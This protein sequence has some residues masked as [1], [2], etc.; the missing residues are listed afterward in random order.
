MRD[1]W[2]KFVPHFRPTLLFLI[3][4]TGLMLGCST[5][6]PEFR[7]NE[8]E[9]HKQE[10]KLL[11]DGEEFPDYVRSDIA[12]LVTALFGTPQDP[13][14][15]VF[16]GDDDPAHQFVNIDNL[17][18]AAG[19]V[20]SDREGR[21]IG[22][23][24]EHCAQCHGV[25]GDG[26]GPTSGFMNPYPRDFRHGRFKFKSTKGRSPPTDEDL[27]R[28]IRQ[29]ITGTAMPSFKLLEDSEIDALVDYVK[30]LSLRG[31]FERLLI[32]E[33]DKLDDAR[34]LNLEDDEEQEPLI[35]Q[36]DFLLE[37]YYFTLLDQ[38]LNANDAGPSRVPPTPSGF[39]NATE[40]IAS[41]KSLF[42]GRA[43]CGQCHGSTGLG[44]G[45]TNNYDVWTTDWLE[46]AGVDP[47]DPETYSE[48][49]DAGA[50][51]P[52]TVKPR[53]LRLRVF[54]GGNRPE[55]IYRRIAHGIDGTPMPAASA[56]QEE[57]IWALVAY[58]M[59]MPDEPLSDRGIEP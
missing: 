7:F 16:E 38:W 53:N 39:P 28:V 27:R 56:L 8:V 13:S 22:L 51:P 2:L 42:H 41:G 4:L 26:K 29:G 15:P 43:N 3:A 49:I 6:Q 44:D 55:D 17:K 32:S 31:Q 52:R 37:D 14:F 36:L 11:E 45:Q 48:F 20:S 59:N 57:E 30:Y 9:F 33:I 1:F 10:R 18:L 54:R 21:Q 23:Y 34:M 19:P 25:T 47:A 58:V 35:D 5:E 40:L 50:F 24:R 46:T 12:D